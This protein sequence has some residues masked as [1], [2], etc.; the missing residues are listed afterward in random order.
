[1]DIK[2]NIPTQFI[3]YPQE[4]KVLLKVD[5]IYISSEAKKVEA[6]NL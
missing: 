1:M 5:R 6:E 3:F 4:V 2:T